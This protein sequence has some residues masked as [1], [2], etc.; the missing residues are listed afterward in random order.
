MDWK[1]Q[2]PWMLIGTVIIGAIIMY[3]F[4][5]VTRS[6]QRTLLRDQLIRSI[7][8]SREALATSWRSARSA[9]QSQRAQP[10]NRDT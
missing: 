6:R 2:D 5:A 8:Q 1:V 4:N 10:S 3:L 9:I 7:H